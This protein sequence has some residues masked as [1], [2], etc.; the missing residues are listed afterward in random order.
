MITRICRLET[1]ETTLAN[2]SRLYPT[3]PVDHL[4]GREEG[5]NGL[6]KGMNLDKN[7]SKDFQILDCPF[8]FAFDGQ[9][10]DEPRLVP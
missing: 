4:R 9:P 6:G 5:A 1:L 7:L 2:K 8:R 3:F 10:Y